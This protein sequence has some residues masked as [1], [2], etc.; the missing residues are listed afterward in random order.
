MLGYRARAVALPVHVMT[1][2]AALFGEH[3]AHVHVIE[4][5]WFARLHYRALATTR[6]R[7][8][9]LRG[10][11]ADFLASPL[12]VLHEYCHVM[13][14]WETGRLTRTRYVVEWLRRGYRRNCFE[15]EARECA[16]LNLGE[17]VRL[18]ERASR[19]T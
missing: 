16:P 14:Q 15:I 6:R 3:A 1:A 11:A 8:I 2:L 5:S 12:L 18:L 7:R 13:H 19:P 17:Y 10:S 9:Y 4:Y